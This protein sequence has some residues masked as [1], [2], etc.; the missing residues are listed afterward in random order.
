MRA[1][2]TDIPIV[3]DRV[4]VTAGSLPILTDVSLELH[5]G[6]L[7][8]LLGPNGSGKTTFLRT[9][10]GLVQ[11]SEGRVTW[12]G[13]E[14]APPARRAF[15][16]QRPVPLRRTTRGNV[17]FAL[18]TAGV[19]SNE[20]RTRA[21]ALLDSVGLGHKAAVPARRLSGGEKQRLAFA[22]AMA[23]NPEVLFLDEPTA[24]LDPQ[25]TKA[26]EDLIARI[27]ASG[28]KVVMAT[29][30]LGSVRRLADEAVLIH[31]GQIVERGP[32]SSLLSAPISQ[33][34]RAFIAG[35]LLV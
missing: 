34:A 23:R 6:S 10:M 27:A 14:R 28:V 1:M 21:D 22:R 12:G 35:E 24:N 30:D 25:A 33:A 8:A 9:A 31:R 13:R 32:A 17:L 11:Q 4:T 7:T 3:F 16:F 5:A 15:V 26:I 19:A 29:H 20:R 18:A 2:P